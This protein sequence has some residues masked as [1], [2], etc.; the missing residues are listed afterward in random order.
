MEVVVNQIIVHKLEKEPGESNS[1]LIESKKILPVTDRVIDLVMRLNKSFNRDD[2]F[3]AT[4]A[5]GSISHYYTGF[6]SY[7]EAA[8]E[9]A[10]FLSFTATALKGLASEL[11]AVTAAKGGY[12]VFINYEVEEKTYFGTYLV[13]DTEGV[14][15]S[16]ADA[17]DVF[18]VNS[19]TY[20]DTSNLAM[21][22]RI[23]IERFTNAEGSYIQ[24]TKHP[25]RAISDYFLRWVD[26]HE[27]SNSED[28]TV[29]LVE[30]FDN[31]LVQE[32]TEFEEE[33]VDKVRKQAYNYIMNK[34]KKNVNLKEI[35][36]YIFEDES[37]LP[38]YVINQEIEIDTEFRAHAPTLKKLDKFVAKADNFEVKFTLGSWKEGR[39]S[40]DN[41]IVI[42]ESQTLADIIEDIMHGEH[43]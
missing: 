40:V 3:N 8:F 36:A 42:I 4:F 39:I 20:L 43:G 5:S 38:N 9:E 37:Y 41:G 30:V 33:D 1:T 14:L 16:L 31:I 19:I 26:V 13:R 25:K 11:R 15:F 27:I 10:A 12:F 7:Y 17:E 34:A 24:F 35:S 6:T 32:G 23:D 2:I 28:N 29:R 22:C 21:A 18:E